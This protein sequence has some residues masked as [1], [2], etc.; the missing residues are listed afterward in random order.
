M[1]KKCYTQIDEIRIDY[2][3]CEINGNWAA[4]PI[5]VVIDEKSIWTQVVFFRDQD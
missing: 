4:L 3:D 5:V 1:R 2:L